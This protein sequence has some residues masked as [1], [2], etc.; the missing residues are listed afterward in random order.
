M[1]LGKGILWNSQKS[2]EREVGERE[3]DWAIY[4]ALTARESSGFLDD[5]YICSFLAQKDATRASSSL[6]PLL[7]Y[8]LSSTSL[9]PLPISF[10]CLISDSSQNFHS[11][12]SPFVC[13]A[14]HRVT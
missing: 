2:K 5:P 11:P 14:V 4:E 12:N 1:F 3:G 7:L 8:F 13:E 6:F 9:L 10:S